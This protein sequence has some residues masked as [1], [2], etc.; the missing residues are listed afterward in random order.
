MGSQVIPA[1]IVLIAGVVTSI[2]NIVNQV[3]LVPALKRLL[4]VMVIFY[5][6]GQI[7]KAIIQ[8]AIRQKSKAS[9][10]QNEDKQE[11]DK[12]KEVEEEDEPEGK[13]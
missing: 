8:K 3:E 11:E 2:I 1:I 12:Q 7:A 10:N 5:F 9:D 4:L 13:K 6:I